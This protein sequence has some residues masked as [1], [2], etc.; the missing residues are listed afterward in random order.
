MTSTIGAM[1]FSP[2]VEELNRLL[3]ERDGLLDT[4]ARADV[5]AR[6]WERFSA[7]RAVVITDMSGFSRI[8]KKHG[9]VHFR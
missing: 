9:I 3:S 1:R 8:T 4:A 7:T 6:I 2:A 5:E